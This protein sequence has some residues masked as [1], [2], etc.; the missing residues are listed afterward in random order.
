MA[1]LREVRTARLLSIRALA[2]QAGVAPSTVYL[3]EAGRTT[4]RFTVIRLAHRQMK[5]DLIVQVAFKLRSSDQRDH[6]RLGLMTRFLPAQSWRD[7]DALLNYGR[8]W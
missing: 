7:L 1:S 2:Q 5:R 6:A 4:P 8:P 3:I